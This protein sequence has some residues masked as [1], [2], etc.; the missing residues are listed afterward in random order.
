MTTLA[1]SAANP[2]AIARPIP[3][4]PP[5][6]IAT[7]PSS[8]GIAT[9]LVLNDLSLRPLDEHAVAHD[10]APSQE[11]VGEPR[12]HRPAIERRVAG[13]RNLVGV[14]NDAGFVGVDDQ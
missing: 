14:G 2:R 13:A 6:T 5:V 11:D 3:E 1:P 4:L 10:F 12:L 9:S 8:S 7:L